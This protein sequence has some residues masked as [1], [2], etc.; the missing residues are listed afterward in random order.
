MVEK[1]NLQAFVCLVNRVGK[2]T[3]GFQFLVHSPSSTGLQTGTK[4][5]GTVLNL[6]LIFNFS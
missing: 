1:E 2:R 6:F 3:H 5:P 4:E